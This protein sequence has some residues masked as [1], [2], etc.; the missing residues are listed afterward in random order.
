M[1]HARIP[2]KKPW[3]PTQWLKSIQTLW[4]QKKGKAIL[5]GAAAVVVALVVLLVCLLWPATPVAYGNSGLAVQIGSNIYYA[6]VNDGYYLY[7]MKTDGTDNHLVLSESIGDM[8]TDGKNLYAFINDEYRYLWTVDLKTGGKSLLMDT[9][10]GNL[11]YTDSYIYYTNLNKDRNLYSLY[12]SDPNVSTQLTDLPA[13]DISS[14]GKQVYFRYGR[15]GDYALCSVPLAG[16]EVTT[17]LSKRV[18][19]VVYYEGKLYY[20]DE[21]RNFCSVQPDGSEDRVISDIPCSNL[22]IFEDQLYFIYNGEIEEEETGSLCRMSLD[23]S[24]FEVLAQGSY[25]SINAVEGRVF[26][27][28]N[29]RQ[30]Y[31]YD[32]KNRTVG[33]IAN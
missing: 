19:D 9:A 6:N 23:G 8:V 32:L 21:N 25:S 31:F 11:G 7:S 30:M 10:S 5:L 1:E 26:F 24:G 17:I 20:I 12:L 29:D 14:D 33:R 2:V 27:L 18:L 16:G 22:V 28:D 15:D 3:H 4:G 13:Y